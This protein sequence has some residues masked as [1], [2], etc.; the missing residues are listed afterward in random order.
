[1]SVELTPNIPKINILLYFS[2]DI[3]LLV[4]ASLGRLCASAVFAVVILHS[5]ELFP[6]LLRNTA[7]GCCSTA[8]HIGSMS[9]PLIVDI[10][11]CIPQN[12]A[13][14]TLHW[15]RIS[16]SCYFLQGAYAWFIPSTV[17]GVVTILAGTMIFL[18][19]ETKDK[20]LPDTTDDIVKAKKCDQMG[21][22]QICGGKAEKTSTT[23]VDT[24]QWRKK[25]LPSYRANYDW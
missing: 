5:T 20:P 7:I 23:Q 3:L 2:L 11:V 25:K 12:L 21:F 8:A 9:A 19:P 16:V 22:H 1:M 15:G 14:W 24:I 17:C 13:P 10:L 18:L 6:T 4:V